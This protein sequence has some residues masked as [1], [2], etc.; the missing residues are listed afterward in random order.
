VLDRVLGFGDEWMPN[1]ISTE[2]LAARVT[3]LGTRAEEAGRSPI[4][5]T[6]AGI[7]PDPARIERVEHAGADRAFFWLPPDREEV[8]PEIE[9]CTA[10]VDEYRRAGG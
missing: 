6:V 7:R 3:E 1:R 9:R 2:D 5:V 10:A 4:P 8:E